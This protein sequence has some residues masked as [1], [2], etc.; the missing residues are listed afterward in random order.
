MLGDDILLN[1]EYILVSGLKRLHIQLKHRPVQYCILTG[2]HK[3]SSN[4]IA[5]LAYCNCF[6]MSSG[7]SLVFSLTFLNTN[8]HN[9]PVHWVPP[10]NYF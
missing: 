5:A 10:R 2:L 4:R 1:T 8:V 7:M 3:V 6:M 9:Q